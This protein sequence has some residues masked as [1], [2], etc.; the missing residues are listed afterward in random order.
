MYDIFICLDDNYEQDT[1]VGEV[2]SKRLK[3]PIPIILSNEYLRINRFRDLMVGPLN[4]EDPNSNEIA[5]FI[6]TNQLKWLQTKDRTSEFAI[7]HE[8]GHYVL[9]HFN[10]A[11]AKEVK[12]RRA[13]LL[14]GRVS[15]FELAADAF[16]FREIG[17]DACVRALTKMM[18]ARKVDDAIHNCS[19]GEKA[20]MAVQE[21]EMRIAAI[22]ELG[23][24]K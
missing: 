6:S 12:N 13:F 8:V 9:G 3:H 23:K 5:I 18:N 24:Q 11:L 16:A 17:G 7:L 14:S 22:K 15:P 2:R 20:K 19:N 21:Y 1:Q 10:P 4:K